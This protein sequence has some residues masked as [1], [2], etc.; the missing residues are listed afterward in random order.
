MTLPRHIAIIM[1]GNG[2]WAKKRHLPRI[3]GHRKGVERVREI[4]RASGEIGIR[5]LTLYTFSSENW[6]RPKKE[7][8]DLMKLLERLVAD[9]EPELM[10]NNV[11]LNAIGRLSDLPAGVF[12]KLNRSIDHL[13]TNTGLVLTLAL[14]YGGR[15]EIV[16]SLKKICAS[17]KCAT[18]TDKEF[19]EFLYDP[20]LPDPDLL[21]RTGGERRISNFLLWQLAYT[22]LYFTE[23]LW[24]DF[25]KRELV[26]AIE[27]FAQRERRFGRV[28]E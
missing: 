19:V 1:D 9:E 11:R 5:Y 8:G 27:D 12:E 6:Q 23:T 18:L 13:H 10:K 25:G 17:G 26:S 21:I 24:P 7:V 22:E 4:V 28:K 14:S 16:D 15:G 20:A 2:R 3:L